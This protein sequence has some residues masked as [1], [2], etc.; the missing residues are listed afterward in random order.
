LNK[1]IA[2]LLLGVIILN[3]FGCGQSGAAKQTAEAVVGAMF[4]SSASSPAE[5]E[6]LKN[7]PEYA[8]AV[9]CLA[10]HLDQNGWNQEKHDFFMSETNNTGNMQLINPRKFSD[11][12]AMKHFGAIFTSTCA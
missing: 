6:M 8:E 12:D 5:L 2:I 7:M 9:N 4:E 1:K 11:E 10:T 3:L